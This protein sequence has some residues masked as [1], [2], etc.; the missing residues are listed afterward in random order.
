MTASAP[1]STAQHRSL[2]T[3]AVHAG[4]GD[5][6]F[7]LNALPVKLGIVCSLLLCFR[8]LFLFFVLRTW[9]PIHSSCFVSCFFVSFCLN[10]LPVRLLRPAA[11]VSARSTTSLARV[12]KA[13]RILPC[14]RFVSRSPS[15]EASGCLFCCWRIVCHTHCSRPRR[16]RNGRK[17][18]CCCEFMCAVSPITLGARSSRESRAPHRLFFI[19]LWNAVV[20]HPVPF[21][22]ERSATGDSGLLSL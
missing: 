14:G 22:A 18:T 12:S 10:V 2:S 4:Q 1:V 6:S 11:V 7:R 9:L 19:P 5:F 3:P 15:H 17:S 8:F 20:A 21:S 16:L 13:R